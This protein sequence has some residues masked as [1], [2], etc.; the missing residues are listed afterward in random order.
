MK[1]TRNGIFVWSQPMVTLSST[2]V[3]KNE[4]KIVT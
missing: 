1:G 4:I 2:L 3:N